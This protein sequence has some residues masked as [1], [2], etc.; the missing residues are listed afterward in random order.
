[1]KK[2]LTA[3]LLPKPDI[4][5]F[6]GE[7]TRFYQFIRA[8]DGRIG[9]I[10]DDEDKLYYLEQFTSGTPRDI[11]R[12]CMFM[13]SGGYQEA[14]RLLMKRYGNHNRVTESFID[15]LMKWPL[16]KA[17]DV[18][19]LDRLA[20]EMRTCHNAVD[21]LM[22]TS[23]ELDHPKTL[24][25]V[26]EKLPFAIQERWRRE[27]DSLSEKE[28]RSPLFSDLVN[29][30]EVEA[31]IA[32]N[33]S[34]GRQAF[35]RKETKKEENPRETKTKCNYAASKQKEETNQTCLLCGQ[36]HSLDGCP[37]FA[38]K[39]LSGREDYVRQQ[40][41]CFGCLKPGHRSRWCRSRWSPY[42]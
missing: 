10:A 31:R 19:G 5:T 21:S 1:M 37:A 9:S 12:G 20:V 2:L 6:S 8:F 36:A 24:K 25:K 32:S 42:H 26:L 13:K 11:V 22:G 30:T 35:S 29:L 38:Q 33:A 3:S 27:V 4:P 14:R 15:R 41:L 7:I 23:N 17:D 28:G 34:F 16:V 39:P 18:S 40:S